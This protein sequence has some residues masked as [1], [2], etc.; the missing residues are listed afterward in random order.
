MQDNFS[1]ELYGLLIPLAEERLLLPR[2]TVAE[3]ITWQQPEKAE[4]APPWQ[5]PSNGVP[6]LIH[7]SIQRYSSFRKGKRPVSPAAYLPP[8]ITLPATSPSG[9]RGAKFPR[10]GG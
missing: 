6:A 9:S 4:N 5:M 8:W 7:A 3:V 10:S 1:D 2:V